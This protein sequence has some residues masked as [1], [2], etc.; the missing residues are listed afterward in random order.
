MDADEVPLERPDVGPETHGP[1]LAALVHDHGPVAGVGAGPGALVHQG[2]AFR[3][4][5]NGRRRNF[6][7]KDVHASC[8]VILGRPGGDLAP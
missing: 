5:E 6:V 7:S 8:C 4:A 3:R 1:G 2:T